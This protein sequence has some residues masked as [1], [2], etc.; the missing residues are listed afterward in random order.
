MKCHYWH[1]KILRCNLQ[2]FMCIGALPVC[3]PF[4]CLVPVQDRRGH[5]I[6][7]TD[8]PELPWMCWE[9]NLGPLLEQVVL[10]TS[11]PSLQGL[12]RNFVS[13]TGSLTHIFFFF[14]SCG[15]LSFWATKNSDK[16]WHHMTWKAASPTTKSSETV[17]WEISCI[18][19]WRRFIFSQR[20]HGGR[21]G[22]WPQTELKIS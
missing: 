19:S 2:S 6:P 21:H 7:W 14:L 10:L 9:S 8:G 5:Q 22:W 4:A 12:F 13:S 3:T 16:G 17:L 20:K 18:I 11:E 15:M 1:V